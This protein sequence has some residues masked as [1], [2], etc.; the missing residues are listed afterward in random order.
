MP[1]ATIP[2]TVSNDIVYITTVLSVMKLLPSESRNTGPLRTDFYIVVH[3]LLLVVGSWHR[4]EC[5][6]LAAS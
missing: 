6:A 2:A 1:T 4:Y 3:L 5:A